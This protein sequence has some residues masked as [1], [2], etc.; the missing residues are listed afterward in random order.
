MA[1]S[2]HLVRYADWR[3]N[4]TFVPPKKNFRDTPNLVVP[5]TFRD[6]TYLADITTMRVSRKRGPLPGG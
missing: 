6:T 5:T 1:T 2:L 3:H 4:E